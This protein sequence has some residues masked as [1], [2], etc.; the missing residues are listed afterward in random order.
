MYGMV[1]QGIR[2]YIRE[3][4]GNEAWSR[5]VEK[6]ELEVDAFEAMTA[7]DDGLTYSL[8]AAVCDV[9]NMSAAEV[10]E[11]FG[12]YWVDFASNT[13]MGKFLTFLDSDYIENI[14]NIN[15]LHEKIKVSMP[16]L[17]PPSFEVIELADGWHE[18]HYHSE[19]EGLAPMVVGLLKGLARMHDQGI[20]L[21]VVQ[22]RMDGADHDVFAVRPVKT[23]CRHSEVA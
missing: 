15:E 18:V 8:V 12:D 9:L 11:R 10:L 1:N 6:A 3:N 7:Y 4:L 23:Q 13:P 16:N 20:E 2:E 17:R 21:K 5:I 14:N 19:R 22:C